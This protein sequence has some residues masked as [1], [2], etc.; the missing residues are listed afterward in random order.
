M[1]W[2]REI[3]TYLVVTIV[4]ALIWA[5]AAG[6][7]REQHTI[8]SAQVQFIVP[9]AAGWVISPSRQ[10]VTLELSGP[11][12]GLQEMEHHFRRPVS[13]VVP[14]IAGKQGIELREQLQRLDEV[15]QSGVTIVSVE[16]PV[17]EL[18]LDPI[19]RMT[20][21]IKPDLS[22]VTPEGEI[23]VDPP[24]AV[25]S[26]PSTARKDLG[27][28]VA[29]TAKF[30][31]FELDGLKAGVPHALEAKLSLSNG[32]TA[33]PEHVLITPAKAKVSFTIRSRTRD[34]TLASVPVMLAAGEEKDN[35]DVVLQTHS[36]ENVVVTADADLVRRI[37]TGEVQ[38]V[39]MVNLTP[40]E[41]QERVASAAVSCFLALVPKPGGA[42]NGETVAARLRDSNEPPTIKLKISE[43]SPPKS[44]KP[45]RGG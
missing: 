6:E 31:R 37:E 28:D 24:E 36:L 34:T 38:V 41:R 4:T 30:E 18:E 8:G 11:K 32:T 22:G 35:I 5:W 2:Q 9:D 25:I 20:V 7:T 45:A 3:W 23:V 27:P 15:R 13:V 16:P 17:A 19:E 44:A 14:V 29:V 10:A 39:A 12:R 40:R 26:L 1:S 33:P 21:K 43:K 42:T